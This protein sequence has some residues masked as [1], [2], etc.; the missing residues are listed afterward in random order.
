MRKIRHAGGVRRGGRF[1]AR[2]SP[3]K[4]KRRGTHPFLAGLI[5]GVGMSK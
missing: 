3:S 5:G 1:T 4:G 2:E